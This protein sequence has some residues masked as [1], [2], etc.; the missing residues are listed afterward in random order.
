MRGQV[1]LFA[2]Q[3]AQSASAGITGDAGAVDAATDHQQVDFLHRAFAPCLSRAEPMLG[4]FP[5]VEHGLDSTGTRVTET[6]TGPEGPS[7]YQ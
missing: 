4:C 1:M 5:I 2:Q 7:R 3:D 6:T